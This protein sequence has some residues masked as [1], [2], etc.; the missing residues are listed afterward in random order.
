MVGR[1][2]VDPPYVN[3]TSLLRELFQADQ[4]STG[5]RGDRLFDRVWVFEAGADDHADDVGVGG[6]AAFATSSQGDGSGEFQLRS[7]YSKN[8]RTR[9]E[10]PGSTVGSLRRSSPVR[11][12]GAASGV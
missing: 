5:R 2:M 6:E 7:R 12:C 9:T 10:N 11:R 1:P 3:S 8:S 4:R